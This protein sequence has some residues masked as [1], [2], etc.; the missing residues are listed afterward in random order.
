MDCHR[1]YFLDTIILLES[2]GLKENNVDE[3]IGSQ[4]NRLKLWGLLVLGNIS[5]EQFKEKQ[6]STYFS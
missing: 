5:I 2:K 3:R 6:T 1:R 4:T